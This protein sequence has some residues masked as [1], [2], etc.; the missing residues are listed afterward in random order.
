MPI[1]WGNP[2]FTT[3]VDFLEQQA[4]AALSNA[5]EEVQQQATAAFECC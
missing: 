1:S 2:D 5:S 3:Y 4:D